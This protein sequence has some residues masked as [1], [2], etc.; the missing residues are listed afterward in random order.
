[1]RFKGSQW[2]FRRSQGHF[3]GSQGLLPTPAALANR[4]GNQKDQICFVII[5]ERIVSAYIY[6]ILRKIQVHYGILPFTDLY[7]K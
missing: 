7:C 6:S 2:R 3:G 5:N 1:M 4:K